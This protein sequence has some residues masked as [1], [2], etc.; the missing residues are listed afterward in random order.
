MWQA[1]MK[2]KKKKI[3]YLSFGPSM[4]TCKLRTRKEAGTD[5]QIVQRMDGGDWACQ[6][7]P[8]LYNPI[9]TLPLAALMACGLNSAITN[10]WHYADTQ[11]SINIIDCS[12]FSSELITVI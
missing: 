3:Q 12:K 10:A 5:I 4:T 2:K 9:S 8:H 11:I 6:M 7:S 1:E